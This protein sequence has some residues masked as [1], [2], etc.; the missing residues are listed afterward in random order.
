MRAFVSALLVA[1]LLVPIIVFLS[2]R[3]SADSEEALMLSKAIAAER[4]GR[5]AET[6]LGAI[7]EIMRAVASERVPRDARSV[8]ETEIEIA[9]RL[10]DFE[11]F[12]EEALSEKKIEADLWC[13]EFSEAEREELLELMV[14]EKGGRKCRN[15]FDPSQKITL[16]GKGR[17]EEVNACA[18]AILVEPSA[19]G[20][21]VR[22][23]NSVLSILYD[24][25]GT[26]LVPVDGQWMEMAVAGNLAMGVSIYDR[27]SG[28]ATVRYIMQGEGVGY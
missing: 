19:T 17:V 12:I 20:G 2:L 1:A 4:T 10:A 24:E 13:G 27:K 9:S 15:C 11:E 25:T 6:S 7:R 22:I 18:L 16:V 28:A 14:E 26:A 5:Q 21:R 3:A 23:G 8:R